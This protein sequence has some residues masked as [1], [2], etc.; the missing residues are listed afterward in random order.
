[1]YAL[2]E[3]DKI[4]R[5]NRIAVVGGGA[6]GLTAAAA[7][8][9]LGV[10]VDLYER[11]P[12]LMHLQAGCDI[13]WVHPHL[14]DWPAEGAE[15]AYAALPLL[16]WHADTASAVAEQLTARFSK[17]LDEGGGT[18]Y[19]EYVGVDVNVMDDGRLTWSDSREG[20]TPAPQHYDAV[21]LALGFGV[22]T[23]VGRGSSSYWRND[24]VNQIDPSL[25]AGAVQ[26]YLVSGTG[27][28]G[29]IDLLRVRLRAF[30]Q[31][32]I[33]QEIVGMHQ[34]AVREALREVQVN[35]SIG[36][37]L[38]RSY[39]RLRE[40][41]LLVGPLDAVR[42]RLREDTHATLNGI[43][44]TFPEALNASGASVLST[45][46]AYLLDSAGGFEYLPGP[47][48]G[49]PYDVPTEQKQVVVIG[50]SEYQFDRVL[51]RH[52][53]E[54]AR[55]YDDAGIGAESPSAASSTVD[56]SAPHWPAGWWGRRSE[57][58]VFGGEQIEYVPRDTRA[59]ATTF[60]SSLSDVIG[61]FHQDTEEVSYRITLHRLI[62]L[63][64]AEYFQQ[65][66]RYAGRGRLGGSVGR[67]FDADTGLVGLASRLGK[68]VIAERAGDDDRFA[69]LW[70][71][72]H[73]TEDGPGSFNVD[74]KAREVN[75][76]VDSLFA[77]PFTTVAAG[78]QKV[79]LVLFVDTST[80]R[81]FEQEDVPRVISAAC[82][83]FA[84]NLETM[85]MEGEAMFAVSDY[86]GAEVTGDDSGLFERFE[87]HLSCPGNLGV[88]PQ[89]RTIGF[90]EP[91][92]LHG[93]QLV[94]A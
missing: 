65:V 28:G 55:V 79:N 53:T 10:Y 90:F 47:Y 13:R 5:G 76:S 58:W 4:H 11:R 51:I 12:N 81:F 26:T 78:G 75:E 35:R 57:G 66:T 15:R 3:G 14:Y 74:T 85:K 6:A 62:R 93:L 8:V 32:R 68:P 48:I 43:K 17:L 56:L 59:L 21:V 38:H 33:V 39:T 63:H 36:S 29:L 77:Y 82:A 54:V 44:S 73:L 22:E 2:H 91:D 7:A 69:A 60:V 45:F 92:V 18:F 86:V 1:L 94:S 27:D 9:A 42:L 41:G 72:L 31:G 71:A 19:N 87:G 20:A 89:F 16:D 84:K 88:P 23:R 37:D 50:G 25:G 64:G 61:Y 30:N 70:E 67:V 24:S 49:G 83:G 80:D 40:E 34:Q 52:G 46:L